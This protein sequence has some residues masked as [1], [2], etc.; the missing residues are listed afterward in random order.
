MGRLFPDDESRKGRGMKTSAQA[1]RARRCGRR[2]RWR[3]AGNA[4]ATQKLSVS[5]TPTS[6]TIKVTQAQTDPQ[7]AKIT[8]YVPSGYTL[9]TSAAPGTNDRHDDRKRSSHVT[10]TSR[11]RSRA[12]SSSRPRTQ[13]ARVRDG[14]PPRRLAAQPAGR[15]P[16]HRRSRST[17]IRPRVPST[18]LGAYKL[19]VVPRACGRAGRDARAARRTARSCSM[20]RSP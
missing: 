16:D 12:T 8:I 3:F 13:R 11:C 5:Q 18:A 2:Q 9:N 14:E 1:D 17:S 15:R 20:R 7:P 19:V 4:L 6:L 10:R